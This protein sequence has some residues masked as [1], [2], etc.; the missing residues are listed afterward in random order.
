MKN[1][2]KLQ[3]RVYNLQNCPFLI[4]LNITY[5][6]YHKKKPKMNRRSN[7]SAHAIKWNNQTK[8]SSLSKNKLINEN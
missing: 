7:S 3:E 6:L 2:Q 4:N 5:Q 1:L 8:Q